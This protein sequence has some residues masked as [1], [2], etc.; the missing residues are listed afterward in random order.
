MNDMTD[1]NLTTPSEAGRVREIIES[2]LREH[3]LC[4]DCGEP[5]GIAEHDGRLW[6]ECASLHARRGVRHAF[7][8]AFHERHRLW[9]PTGELLAAA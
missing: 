3:Q 7:S 9:L 6:V 4:A 5:M 8:A 1:R 2:A